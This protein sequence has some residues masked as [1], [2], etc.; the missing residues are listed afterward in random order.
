[1]NQPTKRPLSTWQ[2]LGFNLAPLWLFGAVASTEGFPPPAIPLW[3]TLALFT[4]GWVSLIGGIWM[5]ATKVQ[6][7]LLS[8]T[9]F[10][11]SLQFDE[12]S[13]HYKTGFLLLCLLVLSLGYLAHLRLR[14]P[15]FSWLGL[16]ISL[17]VVLTLAGV[18]TNNYWNMTETLGLE[19]CMPDSQG[20]PIPPDAPR[21]WQLLW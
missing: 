15:V 1:M 7:A 20:C 9:P 21:W 10:L 14:Q 2:T 16:V 5:R 6:L 8:L 4:L 3:V 17:A 19:N 18:W 13:R 11:L 12:I